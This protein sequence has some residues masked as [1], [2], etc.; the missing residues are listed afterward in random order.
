MNRGKLGH[1]IDFHASKEAWNDEM[2][3]IQPG[4]SLVYRFEA[5]HADVLMCHCGTAPSGQVPPAREACSVG[6]PGVTRLSYQAKRAG[7][8]C[9][10]G[11]RCNSSSALMSTRTPR[12]CLSERWTSLTGSRV[13]SVAERRRAWRGD[14]GVDRRAR[15]HNR[16]G[17][18]FRRLASDYVWGSM[19]I[20]VEPRQ[21]DE[22]VAACIARVCRLRRAYI[23]VV[24]SRR[25][26]TDAL[27]SVARE[28]LRIGPCPVR[29]IARHAVD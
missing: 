9:G 16:K 17:E 3:T 6:P 20:A 7:D 25:A 4:E 13:K 14:R 1:S 22:G 28:L 8:E 23:V 11:T 21:T 26:G 18:R 19:S 24:A 10:V 15:D 5:K 29:V 12:H 27:D 2:R